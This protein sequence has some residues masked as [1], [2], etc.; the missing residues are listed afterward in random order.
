MS[1][2]KSNPATEPTPP[3]SRPAPPPYKPDKLLIGYIEKGQKPPAERG[4]KKPP[5]E[6]GKKKPRAEQG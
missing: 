3:S 6:Q 4:K 5:A 1:E 2:S